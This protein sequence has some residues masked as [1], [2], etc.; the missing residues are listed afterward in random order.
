MV[1]DMDREMVIRAAE[2]Y[3]KCG[4]TN[5]EGRAVKGVPVMTVLRGRVI[6]EDGEVTAEPG[7]GQL[8]R[9]KGGP[10]VD[11]HTSLT[12]DVTVARPVSDLS[13]SLVRRAGKE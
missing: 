8:V 7:Y 2:S 5:L 1:I 11:G 4:W 13:V 9:P 10:E 3:Y 6:F 12:P